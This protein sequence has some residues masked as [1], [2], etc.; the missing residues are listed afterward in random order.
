M[1]VLVIG[2]GGRE[3]ALAWKLSQS[4][5]VSEVFIAPG[6]P[7]TAQIG[8]NI[9]IPVDDIEKLLH[10]A[11]Y[12]QIDLTV[13]GPEAPLAAGIVDRF[14][15]RGLT[16]AGPGRD[17]A[18][19]ESSKVWAKE[20]M[21]AAGVPT[22]RA[23]HHSDF[24]RAAEAVLDMPLP[25]VI[26]ASGLAAGKGVVLAH[27]HQEA[28]DVLRDMMVYRSLGDAADEVLLEDYLAGLEVSVLAITDGT[29]IYP[30]L[31]SCDYKRALDGDNGPNTG[32]MGAYCPAPSVDPELMVE[33]T[34][35]I[36]QPTVD[37]LRGLGI[38]YRGV[39][40]AGLILTP[41]G[42]RVLEY[43]C[44]FGDPE[45]EVLLPLLKS[46][47]AS[48]LLAAAQGDLSS[49]APPEWR[50]GAAVGVVLA[51]GGYPGSYRKGLTIQGLDRVDDDVLVFHAGTDQDSDGTVVTSG[52]RVLTVTAV[53][54]SFSE[55]RHAVYS[56]VAT[57][58]FPDQ[59]YRSDI[60][61]REVR[62]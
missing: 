13:V 1:R 59:Q 35:T 39:L 55:A 17:A 43:N 34:R 5:E 47:L 25:I 20:I 50:D 14:K 41:D 31:P 6:N 27:S 42:P 32:G 56:K 21:N 11:E 10:A 9:P 18:K 30:L 49:V 22:A 33:I 58:T 7:G 4:D 54:D 38:E 62:G 3:H 28:V 60:A 19:I 23:E 52:G 46:D 44:R 16:I 24:E 53:G 57:I 48:L 37:H 61:S 26:K 45:T 12:H 40:Y 51:S 8:A 36:L 29:T 15:E 2:G